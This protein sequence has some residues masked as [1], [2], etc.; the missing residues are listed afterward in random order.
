MKVPSLKDPTLDRII[1]ELRAMRRGHGAW[2][3]RLAPMVWLVDAAGLG[4]VERAASALGDIR[5][6]HGLDPESN[7]GAFFWLGDIGCDTPEASLEQR[8]DAYGQT[9]HCDPRTALR[10]SDKGIHALAALLRDYSQQGRPEAM[11]WLF[12]SG[13]T[14]TAVLDFVVDEQ[15]VRP[16]VVTVNDVLQELPE[17]IGHR[18]SHGTYDR[19]RARIILDD[20]PIRI[21]CGPYETCLSVQITWDMPIWPTWQLT[22][23]IP[24]PHFVAQLHTHRHRA[25]EIRLL[26]KPE[27]SEL[28][29]KTRELHT[30]NEILPMKERFAG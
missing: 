3:T 14:A 23:W 21:D 17:F 8:L 27:V 4:S 20:L 24:D 15:S 16:P 12:Q 2:E 7:I 1:T 22:S 28:T 6:E 10:R 11:I 19:Y 13:V 25:A 29:V 18:E 9:F 26:W 30:T 5:A